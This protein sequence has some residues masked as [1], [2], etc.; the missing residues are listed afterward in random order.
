MMVM[1]T[2][3][4]KKAVGQRGKTNHGHGAR[5]KWKKSGHKGGIGMAGTGKRADHKKTLINKLYGNDYFGKQG[6]TSKGTERDK[7]KK[8]NVGD[9]SRNLSKFKV[10][11]GWI[12]LSDTKI[13]G[14]G[15]ISKKVKIKALEASK[16]AISKIKKAGGE[17]KLEKVDT[18]TADESAAGHIDVKDDEAD[19]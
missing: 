6:I 3:K 10:V 19:K 4:V 16:T 7:R 5:K 12:D 8:I 11:E 13:L 18:D 14:N 2:K 1:K 17:L 9:I 15:E